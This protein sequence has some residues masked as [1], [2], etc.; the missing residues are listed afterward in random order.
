MPTELNKD[1]LLDPLYD[2]TLNMLVNSELENKVAAIQYHFRIGYNRA[3]NLV[4]KIRQDN[5][6][7]NKDR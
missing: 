2:Q 7:L 5:I 1:S 6:S 4:E 3:A